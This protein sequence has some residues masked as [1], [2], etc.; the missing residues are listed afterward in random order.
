MNNRDLFVDIERLRSMRIIRK[1]IDIATNTGYS[2]PVIS[3][4]LSKRV[5]PSRNFLE[6]F[7]AYYEKFLSKNYPPEQ[8]ANDI[9]KTQIEYQRTATGLFKQN[10]NHRI[11]ILS[12]SADAN[13]NAPER[14]WENPEYITGYMNIPEFSDCPIAMSVRGTSMENKFHP[15]DLLPMKPLLDF[16]VIPFGEPFVII[17]GEQILFKYIRK[18]KDA[19]KWVLRCENADYD[20]IDIHKKKVKF[21]FQVKG[22][23]GRISN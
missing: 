2:E 3:N 10:E 20:D 17:T 23:I 15:G 22:R 1:N 21:L 9:E 7:Y 6:K 16:D 19:E 13:P 14:F 18:S 4:Y 8:I 12:I 5:A 11:S